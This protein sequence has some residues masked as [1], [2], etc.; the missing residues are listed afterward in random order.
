MRGLPEGSRLSPTLFGIVMVKLLQLLQKEFP[1]ACT[2][3]SKGPTW[4]GAIAYVDDLVLI[5]KSP[6]EL[7]SMLDTC[8]AWCEKS[9]V[10]INIDK[11]KIMTFYT[12]LNPDRSQD[13]H[14][15]SV[16][17]NFLPPDHP[18]K[19]MP[20][21]KVDS[22]RYLGIPI[23]KDLTM[24]TLH[25][26]ILDNIQK[27]NGKLQRLLRDLE[28][29]RELHSS[30]HSTIGRAS[31]SPKTLCHLWKSCVLVHTSIPLTSRTDLY[32]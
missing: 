5:S 23:Y 12:H 13:N 17:S 26:L 21:K 24:S 31:T 16:T 19:T 2:Y 3:S 22:F 1:H 20:L 7:Q 6:R 10:E 28:S 14:T 8:Q 30:H 4:L 32:H 29:N 25:T 9:R 18:H 11:T 15:W 27:A